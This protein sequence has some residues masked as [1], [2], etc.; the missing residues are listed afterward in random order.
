MTKQRFRYSGL[1]ALSCPRSE[2]PYYVFFGVRDWYTDGL[3]IEFCTNKDLEGMFIEQADGTK[4]QVLGTFQFSL[5]GLSPITVRNKLK[6]MA[7]KTMEERDERS[8]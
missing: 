1:E 8:I 5:A 7:I 6:A 3:I 4:R 2:R